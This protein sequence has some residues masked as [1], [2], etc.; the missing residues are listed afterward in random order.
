MFRVWKKFN[1]SQLT[2]YFGVLVVL[3]IIALAI[4][5]SQILRAQETE[6]WRKQMSNNTLLLSE[7]AYQI[8]AASYMALDGIADKVRAE[9]VDSP[10]A[11]REKLGTKKTFQMLKDKTESLPQV[12]VATIVA[13]NGEVVNFT[14]SYPPPPINLADRDYFKAQSKG[15]DAEGF[16]GTSVRNKGNGKWVFY[17]S[18]RIDDTY[19]NMMGLI[20]VGIS[21][22]V[23]SNFY[24]QLGMNLGNRASM[25]LYRNDFTVLTNWPRKDNLIGKPNKI[26]ATYTIVEK[27]RKQDDVIYL[28]TPKFSQDSQSEARLGAARVIKRYPLIIGMSIT[29][30]F[31]LSNWR[32]SVKGIATLALCCIVALLSGIAVI[33]GVFRQREKDMLIT[34]D[35]KSHAEAANRA[36]SMF[37]ANMSHEIRTPMNG[38][39]GMTE[40]CLNTNID[41]EQQTYLT[42]V[43]SSADNLL[44]IINDILDFSKIEVGKIE[45]NDVPFLLCTTIEEI[46]QSIAIRA[47]EKGLK[48]LF[49]PSPDVPDA[50]VGDP[51]RLRQILI[52]LVGNSI[53]FT[54]SGHVLVSVR[55]VEKDENTCVLSFSVLDEGIGI[56]PEKLEHIFDPFEQGD[57]STTKTYG[58]TGL[59]L[60]ISKNLV[61][62]LGGTIRVESKLGSGSTFTFTARFEIQHLPQPVHTIVHLN[63]ISDPGVKGVTTNSDIGRKL[64]ILVA[65]DVPINQILIL[66]ILARYGHAVTLV[67]NG[68]EAVQTWEKEPGCY[69]LIFMDVQMP[70]MDGFEATRRIRGREASL[71]QHIPI[72]A[73]TAYAMKEDME[74][75]REAGMDDFI[76][77]PFRPE[78]ILSVLNLYAES[79]AIEPQKSGHKN[80]DQDFVPRQEAGATEKNVPEESAERETFDKEELLERLG[81][82]DDMVP[83]FLDMFI[84]NTAGYLVALREAFNTDNGEQVR[85]QAHTIKGAAANISALKIRATASALEIAAREGQRDEWRR[86]L[87]QLDSEYEKFKNIAQQS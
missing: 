27:M 10:H 14:R 69:H 13:D 20:L 53:K 28:N 80:L 51:G 66:A 37:L 24:E 87:A 22:D 35:L 59:G 31:F 29:E 52:N 81:G 77:K 2:I 82:K 42:A 41:T 85:I 68:E 74:K 38:I 47:A 8:M 30:D 23:F 67:G 54:P 60:T 86:L 16:I 84:E 55:V 39:I 46:L 76:S 61:E 19:G 49:D 6:V 57:I 40:L 7:H 75:C 5:A 73:M 18:R 25:T 43:K 79:G 83:L 11:L 34:I 17:I 33:T 36:K 21:V 50:L 58:G 4:F 44:S 63:G 15:H 56:S 71:G 9:G 45:R 65:E 26:G 12:D 64:T 32:N 62:L 1:A 48:V 72:I 70:V 78:D 3:A